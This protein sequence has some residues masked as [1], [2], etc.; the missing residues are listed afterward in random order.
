MGIRRRRLLAAAGTV[1][2]AGCLDSGGRASLGAI[3]VL[4]RDRRAHEVT[5]RLGQHDVPDGSYVSESGPVRVPAATYE[6][7]E[8]LSA[9][10]V[11]LGSDWPDDVTA[12][13]LRTGA[14]P[15]YAPLDLGDVDPDCADFLFEIR[16]GDGRSPP[17]TTGDD[18]GTTDSTDD[19]ATEVDL[20]VYAC[21]SGPEFTDDGI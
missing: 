2:L 16:P 18:G 10:L 14:G 8:L 13:G 19:T 7:G 20:E 11:P 9:A 4:N 15:E 6:D 17:G 21:D 1:A 3:T 5:V 12:V